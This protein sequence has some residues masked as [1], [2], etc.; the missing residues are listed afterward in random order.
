MA[1]NQTTIEMQTEAHKTD[2]ETAKIPDE[3][4]QNNQTTIELETEPHKTDPVTGN[5]P[6]DDTQNNENSE[7]V[8]GI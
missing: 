2:T 7:P 6:D 3:D 4:T 8:G 5:L 1:N